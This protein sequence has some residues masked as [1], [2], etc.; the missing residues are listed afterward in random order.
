M[1]NLFRILSLS[2]FMTIF[3]SLSISAGSFDADSASAHIVKDNS[4]S[5]SDAN[6]SHHDINDSIQ[7]YGDSN[8][9]MSRPDIASADTIRKFRVG[10]VLSGGG[11][12]GIAHIGVI[13]ALEDNDIP[14]DCITG[15]S[16]GAIVGSLYAC[17]LSPEQMMELIKSPVFMNCATGTIAP[18][19]Q[20]YFNRHRPTPQW[21]DVNISFKDS[22]DN[23]I[24]GQILPSSFISPIP[25]NMEFL[26]LYAPYSSQCE[27]NFD[28][29]MVPFRCVTSDV[30]H[31][32]KIVL[33][34]GLLGRAVRA[35]MSFPLVFRPIEM[36][37]VLVFDGGIYDNFPVDVMQEDFNPDF[38]I[39]V[40]VSGP[41]GKPKKDNVMSQ[42]EDMI[43]QNNDYSVPAE[44]GIKIQCPVLNFGVLDFGKSDEIYNIGYKTGLQMV[45]SIKSRIS[46]RRPL[47]DVTRRRDEFAAATPELLFDSVAVLSGTPSQK[48]YLEF[49][50]NRGFPNRPFNMTQCEKGYYRAISSGKLSNLM[51]T[52]V[53]GKPD[54]VTPGRRQNNI[55]LL[56]PSIKNPWNIGVG[57]W[58]S[59]STESM[60][61]VN[62]GYHT[63]SFNSLDADLSGWIGQTYFAGMLSGK[64]TVHSRVPSYIRLEGILSR[65][66]FYDSQLMFFQENNATSI[67]ED[68]K[69]IR[70]YYCLATGNMSIASFSATYGSRED[71]YYS[72]SDSEN[73]AYGRNKTLTRLASAQITWDYNTL[74]S[75][76]YP[77]SGRRL[78]FD[79]TGEWNLSD[80]YPFSGNRIKYKRHFKASISALW[81]EFF[82]LHHNFRLGITLDAL[83]TLGPL[84]QNYT[85]EIINAPAFAPLPSVAN[86][87]NPRFRSDNYV[88]A[89]I[90]PVWNPF[91]KLQFR[92][93]IYAFVP[94]RNIMPGP[95]GSAIRSGWFDRP[96]FI[97]QISAVYNFNF[98]SLSLYCNYLSNP[99][100]NW[101][102]G[103]SFGFFFLAPKI[104]R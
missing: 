77:M 85:A 25:M 43:I 39:G 70:A 40:S 65:Q 12:K 17:G 19:F 3:G 67:T 96:G 88:A 31:K 79:I 36:D 1:N 103:I 100:A 69:F 33:K 98:A 102:F 95:D 74:S 76:I 48:R 72:L 90:T 27:M 20:Y 42:L 89:G 91:Q 61:Y 84:Y 59:T 41:D 62:F 28:R 23:D 68:Q 87:F 57:G 11:A 55:L 47:K 83:M 94:S 30:Y 18:E 26:R 53:L 64:F 104:A 8:N 54:S 93:D 63:L 7:A 21:G 10:L 81:T 29:L 44:N 60:L 82:K 52:P 66:K 24:A 56:S 35:S 58:L 75:D 4:S 99:E 46:F 49:L 92:G 22:A 73:R 34:D 45:D 38:I 13:K 80:F 78:K 51:P 71:Q 9:C 97:S 15:T 2:T 101:N 37:G 32:H 50:F 5:V 14:I 16:M 86:Y 6:M